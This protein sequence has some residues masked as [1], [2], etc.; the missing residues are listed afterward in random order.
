MDSVDV[1][2]RLARVHQRIQSSQTGPSA[3]GHTPEGISHA[4]EGGQIGDKADIEPAGTSHV[5][6]SRKKMRSLDDCDKNEQQRSE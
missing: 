2:R 1:V 4:S 5:E 6:D 3:A